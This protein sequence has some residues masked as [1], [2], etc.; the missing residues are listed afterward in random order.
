[1]MI[2]NMSPIILMNIT[3]ISLLLGG[4][5]FGAGLVNGSVWNKALGALFSCL[6]IVTL[7]VM[8]I[9]LERLI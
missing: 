2:T 9:S 4:C 6:G 7:A 1:M 8:T 3:L 5:L